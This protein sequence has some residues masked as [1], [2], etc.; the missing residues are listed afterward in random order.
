MG[1][2]SVRKNNDFD[3]IISDYFYRSPLPILDFYER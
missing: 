2:F 1:N 3:N